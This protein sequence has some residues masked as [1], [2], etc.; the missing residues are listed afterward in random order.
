MSFEDSGDVS[1][2]LKR[3]EVATDANLSLFAID[4]LKAEMTYAM[5]VRWF[6]LIGPTLSKGGKHKLEEAS[7]MGHR[8]L[9]GL[10]S[11]KGIPVD[12]CKLP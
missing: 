1:D 3:E 5:R 12:P 8:D 4:R 10:G 2:L 6:S 7:R 9:S 11:V